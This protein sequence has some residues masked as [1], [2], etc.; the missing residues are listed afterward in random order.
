MKTTPIWSDCLNANG[1]YNGAAIR[2][3]AAVHALACLDGRRPWRRIFASELRT[4]RQVARGLRA[5]FE[6]RVTA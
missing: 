3:I 4:V 2:H 1:T 6:E 5:R